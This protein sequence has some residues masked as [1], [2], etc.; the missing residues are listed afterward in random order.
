M[1]L[2]PLCPSA[3]DTLGDENEIVCV[4]GAATV[5]AV[6]GNGASG[7]VPSVLW[8]PLPFWVAQLAVLP[9]ATR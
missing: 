4:A 8:S 6:V 7:V 2:V 1:V 5:K 3:T 9:I